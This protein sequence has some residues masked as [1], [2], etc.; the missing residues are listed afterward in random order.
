[1][2]QGWPLHASSTTNPTRRTG[3]AAVTAR[4]RRHP[5]IHHRS[6]RRGENKK[7]YCSICRRRSVYYAHACVQ[8]EI[9]G[10]RRPDARGYNVRCVAAV[11]LTGRTCMHSWQ[12][13]DDDEGS[14]EP[15]CCP[16]RRRTDTAGRTTATHRRSEIMHARQMLRDGLHA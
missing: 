2:K 7:K 3:V 8:I 12:A 11:R 10:R 4:A 13:D 16:H 9:D 14:E 15:G 5:S 6:R 1:M